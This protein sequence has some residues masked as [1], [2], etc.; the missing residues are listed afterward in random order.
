M[1][2][3]VCAILTF[4]FLSASLVYG[5]QFAPIGTA[6]AQ[7]LEIGVGARATGMGEAYTV[8]VDDASAVFWNPAGL[9]DV[10]TNNL[11]TSYTQWPAGISIGG[12]SIAKNFRNMG[13]LGLS[14]VY[15]MTNDMEVT[16]VEQPEGTGEMFS[17][18]NYALGLTYSRYLTDKVSAGLTAKLVREEYYNY[19][20]YT[21]ALDLGTLYRTGFHGLRIGM[22]I[23]HFAPEVQFDGDYIDYSDPLSYAAEPEPKP[24]TFEEYSLPVNFRFGMAIDLLDTRNHKVTLA[25]DM[26]HPNNNIEQ[27]N[28]GVEYG[29]NEL[30]YLRTGY[31][32]SADEGG[33]SF[34]GGAKLKLGSR[35]GAMVNYSFCDLGVLSNVNR[36]SLSLIF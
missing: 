30:V 6:V 11:F 4:I 34:G 12:M 14:T 7:F 8:M 24:K 32:L 5:D 35:M 23:L 15:L 22:S 1:R 9:A 26:I 27:Y 18:T 16:T 13:T 2:R 28:M 19:G 33:L 29:F 31:K 17:I 21:W 10:E 3:K 36:F 20:Y 25:S